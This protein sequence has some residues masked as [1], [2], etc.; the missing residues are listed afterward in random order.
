MSA[1]AFRRSAKSETKK[2]GGK[3]LRGNWREA[4]RLPKT[5]PTPFVL[6]KGDYQDPNPDQDL[7]EVGSNGQP[8]PVVVNYFKWL[9]HRMKTINQKTGKPLFIDE[10]CAAGWDKH[11]K[12]PCAACAASDAGDNRFTLS[13]VYS[14]GLIHLAQY[15]RHPLIDPKKGPIQHKDGSPVMV[16][17]ECFGKTCNYCR[18]LSGQQPVLQQNEYWPPYP[19]GS[20]TTVFGSRR[21]LELGKGHLGDLSAW[22]QQIGA[23]CGG[24]AYVRDQQGNFVKDQYGNFVPKGRCNSFLDVD[25]YACPQCNNLLINAGQDP[26][27]IEQLEQLAMQRYPCHH[28]QRQVWLKELNSCSVC[29]NAKVEGVFDGVL[30]GQRQGEDTQSHLVLVQYDTIEDF[31]QT[32]IHPQVRET[33]G[34]SLREHIKELSKPYNFADLYKPKSFEDQAKRLDINLQPQMTY[35]YGQPPA[36]PSASPYPAAYPQAGGQQFMPAQPPQ[37][38]YQ[39]QQQTYAPYPP[40]GASTTGPQQFVPYNNP[41][42]PAPPVFQPPPKPNFGS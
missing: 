20:I 25:G 11:N 10:V 7:I 3:G 19:Q 17:S 16:D 30:W 4:F 35:G 13:E 31:E 41:N 26:R 29:G 22:D 38:Q 8:L 12:Q 33:L 40:P 37:P 36:Y 15:H 39:P 18:V 23:R 1:S 14:I 32:Q 42:S 28:C 24:I 21:Y 34:K 2:A 6:I 27:P 5:Q 9:R